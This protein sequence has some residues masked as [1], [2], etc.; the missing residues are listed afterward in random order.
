MNKSLPRKAN[1][2]NRKPDKIFKT[3]FKTIILHSEKRL[4]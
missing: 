3:S 1:L 2:N 4:R